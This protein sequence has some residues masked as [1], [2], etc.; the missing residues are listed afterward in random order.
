MKIR[1]R[2]PLTAAS[3]ESG[4]LLNDVVSMYTII[5]ASQSELVGHSDQKDWLGSVVFEF[6]IVISPS[7]LFRA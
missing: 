2:R 7:S 1:N 6:A 5:E 4:F 3:T